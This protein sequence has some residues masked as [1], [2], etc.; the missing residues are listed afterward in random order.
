[1]KNRKE[2]MVNMHQVLIKRRDALR[3]AL[4]GDLSK[5]KELRATA[6]GD[7]VDWALDSVQDEIS[8][9]LAEVESREL[10]RIE[11]ALERMREG[12]Y[13]IC[14]GCG[15]NIPMARLN[16][17]PYATL[18]IKCQRES[19]REGGSGGGGVDWTRLVDMSG[20]DADVS[21]NDIELDVS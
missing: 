20:S 17:L 14:E 18:C 8:S 21:I 15:C 12:Q 9:Q 11:I 5:L 1:M 2:A 19:E 7:V 6:S 10:A 16:A 13:G 3:Q 4:A